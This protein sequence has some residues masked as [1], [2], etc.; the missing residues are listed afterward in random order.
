M[1]KGSSYIFLGPEIGEKQDTINEIKTQLSKKSQPEEHSFYA[2]ET[3]VSYIVSILQNASLFAD[4]RLVLVKNADVIKKEE[5]VDLLAS[6]MKKPQDD[7]ILILISESTS[8]AKALEEAGT[9]KIFWELFENKKIEW[10]QT[11]FRRLGYKISENGVGAIL[12]LVENNTDAM[13]RE[14]TRLQLFLDKNIEITAEEIE[15][16]LSHSREESAFTLFSRIAEG[17]LSKSLTTLHALLMAKEAP[18]AILAGLAW[19]FR[20]LRNYHTLVES[21]NLNDFELKKIGLSLQKTRKDYER[22]NRL[23]N[24]NVCLS[25]TAEYDIL[26]RQGGTYLEKILMDMYLYKIHNSR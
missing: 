13:R 11:F 4:S 25:L 9:K 18:P 5:E 23:Y 21:K 1:A 15:K 14:C 24:A 3:S 19:C 16:W 2:N 26:V 20:K 22:A 17:D 6:Y 8:L 12:E 7:T 10:I